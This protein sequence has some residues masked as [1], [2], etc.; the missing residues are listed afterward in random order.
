MPSQ[1]KILQHIGFRRQRGKKKEKEKKTIE[2]AYY[3]CSD[4]CDVP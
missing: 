1:A 3:N 4:R 2:A